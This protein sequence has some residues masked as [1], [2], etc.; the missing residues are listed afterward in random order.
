MQRIWIPGSV[1]HMVG[2][3]CAFPGTQLITQLITRV[4]KL[5]HGAIGMEA[6]LVASQKSLGANNLHKCRWLKGVAKC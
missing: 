3:H 4:S 2:L 6:P 5:I 1:L